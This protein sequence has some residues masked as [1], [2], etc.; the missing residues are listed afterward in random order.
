MTTFIPAH[1]PRRT[2]RPQ[3]RLRLQP[4]HTLLLA[5]L[6][7]VAITV[8]RAVHHQHYG[9]DGDGSRWGLVPGGVR[10]LLRSLVDDSAD[11]R[12]CRAGDAETPLPALRLLRRWHSG[13]ERLRR[14]VTLVTQLSLE[15]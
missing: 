12:A 7:Y 4:R 5:L 15:R 9:G 2:P 1:P 8:G 13:K 6:A 11:F 14:S 3:S 10:R